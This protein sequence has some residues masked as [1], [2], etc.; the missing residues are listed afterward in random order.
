MHTYFILLQIR[1]E[2]LLQLMQKLSKG[3]TYSNTNLLDLPSCDFI[4]NDY[5]ERSIKQ[6][7]RKLFYSRNFFLITNLNL[8][9]IQVDN[10]IIEQLCA[11]RF[12]KS[13]TSIDLS[14]SRIT[15]QNLLQISKSKYLA[16]LRDLTINNCRNI[17]EN[18]INMLQKSRSLIC[19]SK[20]SICGRLIDI[21]QI[22][23]YE[24]IRLVFD[25]VQFLSINKNMKM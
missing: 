18:G 25:H 3:Q 15:D 19:L 23:P 12:T 22:H 16:R 9:T 5:K 13:L 21:F 14:N 7:L 2:D 10:E 24:K 4:D 11:S 1:N 8:S 6:D 17:T 20:I